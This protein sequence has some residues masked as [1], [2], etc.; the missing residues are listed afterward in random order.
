MVATAL[1]F[2]GPYSGETWTVAQWQAYVRTFGADGVVQQL[3]TTSALA[4]TQNGGGDRSVNVAAGR[5]LLQGWFGE[6]STTKNLAVTTNV[7][8]NPR[9]DTVVSRLLVGTPTFVL[10]VL[11][12]TPAGVPVA[13]TLTQTS[14][15]YEVALAWLAVANGFVSILTANITDARAW[16]GAKQVRIP[17]VASAAALNVN[18]YTSAPSWLQVPVTGTTTITSITAGA[19]GAI[20]TLEFASANCAVTSSSALLLSTS[21]TSTVGSTL[22]LYSDGTNWIEMARSLPPPAATAAVNN[23]LVNGA[24]DVWQRGT[25][26]AFVGVANGYLADR[27]QWI[28]TAGQSA[29]ITRDTS[30]PTVASTAINTP[31]SHKVAITI[32]DAAIAAGDYAIIGQSVEGFDYR[33]L[34]N[35]FSLSFW[36]KAHRTGT[37]CVS[38]RNNMGGT[39][40][41]SY[42][43]EYTVSVAD[44]WEYKSITVT[45]PPTAGTWNYTTSAALGVFFAMTAGTTFQTTA[46]TWQVGNFLATSNQVNGVG[47]ATDIFQLALVNLVP[48]ATAY[49]LLPLPY[50][51]ILARCQRY[52][53]KWSGAANTVY[54]TG[55]NDSTTV[56]AM[57]L[58]FRTTMLGAPTA[59][60]SAG[61]TFL[62][63]IKAASTVA[64]TAIALTNATTDVAFLSCTVAA[65]LTAGEGSVLMDSGATSSILLESNPA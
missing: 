23:A 63:R 26:L 57:T 18:V 44:T 2:F 16:N 61:N 1:D 64:M 42:V 39:P 33:P 17:S 22:T 13:P 6:N 65:G 5:L 41:R 59:T 51:D 50:E 38:F 40:D 29:T 48:G 45:T 25:T 37:Y 21:Y 43:A 8:G 46:N 47:A 52:C 54:A 28:S 14:V 58:P 36:V 53:Q 49:P 3:N 62:M 30:V 34:T 27:W 12:G 9:I 11:A 7:S 35:G 24:F 19:A 55:F 4:V 56:A 10:D 15:T 20:I 31:Y 32:A 60:L